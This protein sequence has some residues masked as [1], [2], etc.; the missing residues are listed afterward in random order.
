LK[1]DLH[2]NFTVGTNNYP[3]STQASLHLLD[4]HSKQVTVQVVQSQDH[5]FAQG[6][7][8]LGRGGGRGKGRGHG[9]AKKDSNKTK[10]PSKW[11]RLTCSQCGG[12]DHIARVC[13]VTLPRT[14]SQGDNSHVP[15]LKSIQS[16]K[17]QQQLQ[18]E[19]QS[20]RAQER[21]EETVGPTTGAKGGN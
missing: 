7:R 16:F 21:G 9:D 20:Q 2:N 5:S 11:A 3:K 10:D 13:K 6:G 17:R 8:G 14:A 19:K 4:R 18:Q 1:T 12:K 15:P